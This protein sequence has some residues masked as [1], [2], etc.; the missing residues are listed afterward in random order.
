MT[1]TN[2]GRVFGHIA[3]WDTC[4]VGFA[5]QCVQPPR[6]QSGYK[7]FT[8]G[9]VICDDGSRVPVGQITMDTGHAPLNANGARAAAHYD[10]TGCAVVDV[11]AG[12]DRFGIWMSGALR[13]NVEPE[14]IRALLASDVSGDWRRIGAGLELV[15]LLAVNVPGFPKLREH[16]GLVASLVASLSPSSDPDRLRKAADRIAATIGRSKADRVAELAKKV[17]GNIS[18]KS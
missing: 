16:E 17:R 10:D 6:S 1:V 8:T 18:E 12:E 2:E 15:G 7:H 14:K 5:D 11:T 3:T 13:P 4:H 9:E